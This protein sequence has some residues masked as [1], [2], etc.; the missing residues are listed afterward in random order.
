[1]SKHTTA[2]LPC[3]GRNDPTMNCPTAW[4]I[5]VDR[6]AGFRALCHECLRQLVLRQQKENPSARVEVSFQGVPGYPT[7][8]RHPFGFSIHQGYDKLYVK[9]PVEP[10]RAVGEAWS[11][12][13]DIPTMWAVDG[14]GDAWKNDAH[15]GDVH[16]VSKESLLSEFDGWAERVNMCKFMDLPIPEHP[17][18]VVRAAE[19]ERI[20]LALEH[21]GNRIGAVLVR[22]MKG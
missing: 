21:A 14:A 8:T 4:D 9:P 16:R 3:E 13:W 6:D 10:L 20:A 11:V 7:S 15:G 17:N 19:R 12:G 22:A 2:Y 1:M 18:D 5:P